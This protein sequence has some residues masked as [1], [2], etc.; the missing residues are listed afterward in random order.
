MKTHLA[1]V[2]LAI[3]IAPTHAAENFNPQASIFIGKTNTRS[4]PLEM[5]RWCIDNGI[6]DSK[7]G[8]QDGWEH[9]T[10]GKSVFRCTMET[11]GDGNEGSPTVVTFIHHFVRT[12]RSTMR[13]ER[14]TTSQ[15]F[16][17]EI[18]EKRMTAGP[19]PFGR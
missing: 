3:A 14:V 16:T 15:G 19:F 9:Q 11:E 13:L 8:Q 17:L 12:S 2:L 6:K 1:A 7:Q 18:S 4:V 10:N 5:S